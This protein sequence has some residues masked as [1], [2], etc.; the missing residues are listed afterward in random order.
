MDVQRGLLRSTDQAIACPTSSIN[1]LDCQDRLVSPGIASGG[2][3]LRAPTT[4]RSKTQ[5]ESPLVNNMY[6]MCMCMYMCMHMYM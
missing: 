1:P 6:N 3:N 5:H 2:G 4:F